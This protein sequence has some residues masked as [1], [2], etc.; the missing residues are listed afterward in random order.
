LRWIPIK[1]TTR[2][3]A[4]T[5]APTKLQTVVPFEGTSGGFDDPT[6]VA[7]V[8]HSGPA[9]ARAG[10]V[11]RGRYRLEEVLIER[12]GTQTW[13]AHDVVLARPVRVHLL[14]NDRS[15]DK[16]LAAAKRA[17]VANDFRVLRVLDATLTADP[18]VVDNSW[19]GPHIVCEYAPGQLL[20]DLLATG[21]LST[22]E[23]AWLVREVADAL[24]GMHARGLYHQRLSPATIMVSTTGNAKISG[25]VVE[26]AMANLHRERDPEQADVTALGRLLYA[27]L[28][29]RWPGGPA[30][31]LDAAPTDPDGHVITPREIERSVPPSLDHI[32]D[33]ILNP[34][35]NHSARLRTAAEVSAALTRMLG[36]ADAAEDLE[37]RVQ[38][39]IS[40]VGEETQAHDVSLG[41]ADTAPL[42]AT[43]RAAVQKDAFA[44]AHAYLPST[45]PEPGTLDDPKPPLWRRMLVPLGVLLLVGSLVAVGLR[46]NFSGD[47]SNEPAPAAAAAP[48]VERA[49]VAAHD[50]DPVSNG[51]NGEEHPNQVALAWDGDPA[52]SWTT[53]NYFESGFGI[54]RGVG[55]VF[56][57]G[58]VRELSRVELELDGAGTSLDIRVPVAE[59]PASAPLASVDDWRAVGSVTGAPAEATVT[60]EQ[61][62]ETRYVLVFLTEL[63]PV[64]GQFTGGIAEARFWS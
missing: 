19:L 21:P 18:G 55:L 29:A 49:V 53:M 48:S 58:E 32:C 28:V 45:A 34:S 16:I 12:A 38:A 9:R 22:L 62:V 8:T 7:P 42:Q 4:W 30:Y 3:A 10:H 51:G 26:A 15:N 44:T 20:Q 60:V 36:T 37:Q 52:T 41:Y 54:K 61:G 23:A 2:T 57:L 5:E 1:K 24:I 40:S 39:A 33:R 13:R 59:N 35:R 25:F 63:P 14:P 64:A 47:D 56:D 11:L 31:G 46:L 6:R 17:A 43:P 50:F 27:L